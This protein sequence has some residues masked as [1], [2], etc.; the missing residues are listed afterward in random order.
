MKKRT[1]YGGHCLDDEID[2]FITL[3]VSGRKFSELNVSTKNK[4]Y[5][6]ATLQKR[7][8]PSRTIEVTYFISASSESELETKHDKLLNILYNAGESKLSFE[9]Q[10]GKYYEA[11]Y[12]GEKRDKVAGHNVMAT[13]SFLCLKPYAYSTQEKIFESYLD[14]DKIRT[15]DIVNNGNVPAEIDYQIKFNSPNAFIGIVSEEGAM[16]YGAKNYT[17]DA[18]PESTTVM[19]IDDF[20]NATDDGGGVDP[21]RPSYGNKGKLEV[22]DWWG[23]K[24]LKIYSSGEKVGAIN[25]GSRTVELAEEIGE[26][27]CSFNA[28]FCAKQNQTG[29]MNISFMTADNRLVCGLEWNKNKTV[30]TSDT[31]FNIVAPNGQGWGGKFFNSAEN[32]DN[33]WLHS[34]SN[35]GYLAKKGS[36]I[37]Y[38][39]SGKY[40]T[41]VI[42]ESANLKIKKVKIA[43]R[44][45]GDDDYSNDGLVEYMG[46]CGFSL[47][48]YDIFS[49]GEE[50]TIDGS[51]TMFYEGGLPMQNKEKMGTKYFKAKVGTTKVQFYWSSWIEQ[52]PT[53]TAKIRERWM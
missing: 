29:Q 34:K 26:F 42:P 11:V 2:G 30:S 7:R 10:L 20:I 36:R 33:P 31:T 6:G 41:L 32:A 46:F 12:T 24:Y 48:K 18:K 19:T 44:Q 43:I 39:D 40:S 3:Q 22:V 15:I 14:S 8:I 1:F 27:V 28:V 25:G 45:N 21:M 23:R 50:V 47:S 51:K 4:V 16:Q 37:T 52:A 53:V 9:D 5:D 17:D 49:T 13:I 35:N 38:Y